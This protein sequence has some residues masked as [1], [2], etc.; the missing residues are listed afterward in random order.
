MWQ[1]AN[2]YDWYF[3]SVVEA[4]DAIR[5]N[6]GLSDAGNAVNLRLFEGGEFYA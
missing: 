6:I 1:I 3:P 5:R 2:Q 4:H